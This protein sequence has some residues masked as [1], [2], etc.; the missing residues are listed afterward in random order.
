MRLLRQTASDMDDAMR[1]A[2][3]AMLTLSP[4]EVRKVV[5]L[6]IIRDDQQVLHGLRMCVC[7]ASQVVERWLSN[8]CSMD[9]H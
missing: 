7:G 6:A 5:A 1:F 8:G 9:D 2:E 3:K 4:L